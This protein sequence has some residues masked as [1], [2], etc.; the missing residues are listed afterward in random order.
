[1]ILEFLLTINLL[2]PRAENLDLDHYNDLKLRA[3][4]RVEKPVEIKPEPI[5]MVMVKP[6][7]AITGPADLKPL[8][9]K[10]GSE[11]GVSEQT[12][13]KIAHC[14][15]TFN[16]RAVNGPYAG[17]Y[18]FVAGTWISQ[19]KAMGLDPNLNLRFNA[20]EAIKTT[21]FKISRDGTGAWPVCGR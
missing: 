12:L 3:E 13:E 17:M 5:V 4:K 18:Q 16:P 15:S 2:S 14:E 11:Y 1:M 7:P 8:F 20:E 10:Y 6:R 21:A 9:S 19:R